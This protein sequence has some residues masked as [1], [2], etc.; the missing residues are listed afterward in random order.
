[1][2]AARAK[3]R[4]QLSIALPTLRAKGQGEAAPH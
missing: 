4:I 2:F 1:M 3:E